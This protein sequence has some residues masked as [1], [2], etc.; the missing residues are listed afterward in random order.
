MLCDEIRAALSSFDACESTLAGARVKTHCL[1]PSFEAVHV[2]IAKVG[3]GFKV[4][5]DAG[6]AREAWLHG[7][8]AHMIGSVL[9]REASRYH[10]E[11]LEDSLV[12][13]AETQEWMLPSILAVANASAS[14]ANEAVLRF[15]AAAEEALIGKIEIAL[16][17]SFQ[18]DSVV[19]EFIVRGK[20]GKEHRFDFAVHRK[21]DGGILIDAVFPN[22]SCIA[23]KYVAFA[24]TE[25]NDITKFAVYDKPLANDDVSLMQQVALIVPFASLI[26][27]ARRVLL[28]A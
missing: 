12:A 1:Y 10:L 19:K 16:R 14:A 11:V 5:D 4:H 26:Q 7:R 25:A 6:A 2:F 8:D 17:E 23:A 20:S 22:Q 13:S 21:V 24:D 9:R 15:V 28:H 27:G 3:D 18:K